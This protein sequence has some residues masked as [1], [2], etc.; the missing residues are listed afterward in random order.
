M[1]DQLQYDVHELMVIPKFM[2]IFCW[3][4]ELV[5]V[6]VIEFGDFGVGFLV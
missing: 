5:H 1:Q 2:L 6:V 4:I 3:H